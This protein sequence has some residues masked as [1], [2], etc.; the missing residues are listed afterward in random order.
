[1]EHVWNMM[2]VALRSL[3]PSMAIALRIRWILKSYA[4]SIRNTTIAI[5]MN[6]PAR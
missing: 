2:S 3:T 5:S 1:M 4:G 6:L